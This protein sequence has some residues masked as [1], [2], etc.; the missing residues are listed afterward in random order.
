VNLPLPNSPLPRSAVTPYAFT[1]RAHEQSGQRGDQKRGPKAA[2]AT[3]TL[4]TPSTGPSPLW[5]RV[6]SVCA[7]SDRVR[8]YTDRH[9]V[10]AVWGSPFGSHIR[11]IREV[12]LPDLQA[13]GSHRDWRCLICDRRWRSKTLSAAACCQLQ[14][15]DSSLG[16]SGSLGR[17]SLRSVPLWITP[18]CVEGGGRDSQW[19]QN[20]TIHKVGHTPKPS[21]EPINGTVKIRVLTERGCSAARCVRPNRAPAAT[22][23]RALPPARTKCAPRFH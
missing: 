10:G 22:T 5:F 8:G 9:P 2:D 6:T 19:A 3:G 20:Y 4:P 15:P 1:A 17:R 16:W 21:R 14:A 13:G 12:G 18:G 11:Q 7:G 23:D